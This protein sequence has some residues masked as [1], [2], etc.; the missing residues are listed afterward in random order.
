MVSENLVNETQ[1][2]ETHPNEAA[3]MNLTMPSSGL[4]HV[5]L[6]GLYQI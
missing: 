5:Q 1:I 3:G 6:S 4:L 2:Q